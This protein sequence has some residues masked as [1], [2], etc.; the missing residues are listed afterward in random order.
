VTS[1]FTRHSRVIGRWGIAELTGTAAVMA[2]LGY[3]S[4]AMILHVHN[5]WEDHPQFA[6]LA[7]VARLLLL[8][9]LLAALMGVFIAIMV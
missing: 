6:G 9:G 8:V 1:L 3:I 5:V 2:G 4:L 7:D